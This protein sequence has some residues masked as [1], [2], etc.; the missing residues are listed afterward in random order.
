MT[1]GEL[2]DLYAGPLGAA[3]AGVYRGRFLGFLDTPGARDP[4][5]RTMQTLMFV[6]PRWG[7]DFRRRLWWFGRP[8][9]AAGR[10]EATR[11]HSRWRDAEVYRLEYET[12]RLPGPVKGLLYDEVKTLPDGKVI[13]LGGTNAP[14]GRGDHFFF[15]LS[16]L[17]SG[18]SR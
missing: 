9:L 15:S 5:N 2:E 11:G 1:H 12:S 7:I 6:W 14:Q 18:G 17:A 8:E 13:G 16:R 4:F 3:P 10:F